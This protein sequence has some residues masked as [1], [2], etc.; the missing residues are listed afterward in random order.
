MTRVLVTGGTGFIGRHVVALLAAKGYE[1]HVV[2]R[3][4]PSDSRLPASFTSVDLLAPGQPETIVD[5]VR[6]T[7]LVHLAWFAEAGRFWDDPVNDHWAEASA[8]LHR[9]FASAGGKRALYAGSC[10]EY[11]W[12]DRPLDEE[13][14]PCR[15]STRYGLAKDRARREIEE[16]GPACTAWAR[17]FFLYG[18][19]QDRGRLIADAAA[20]LV[21]GEPTPAPLAADARDYMHVA[22]VAEALVAVLHSRHSGPINIASGRAIALGDTMDLMAEL[23]SRPDLARSLASA[24]GRQ[25]TCVLGATALLRR[26][27]GGI[28]HRELA[29]GLRQTLAW[30]RDRLEHPP[31]A[32]PTH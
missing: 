17:I 10:A 14:T 32:S 22:D 8:A 18:P 28:P 6:P 5:A 7:H 23:V 26:V 20:A 12:D 21:R 16:L 25:P 1:T 29:D 3:R 4:P 31:G 24:G 19:G 27:I 2:G 9:A 15:P 13:A 30:W 11:A